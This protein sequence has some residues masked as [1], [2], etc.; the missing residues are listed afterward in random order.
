[1]GEL[2]KKEMVTDA[3][4]IYFENNFKLVHNQRVEGENQQT[5][6]RYSHYNTF[7]YLPA[8]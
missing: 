7:S 3:D 5:F 6:L 2:M 4:E 8:L 1:V